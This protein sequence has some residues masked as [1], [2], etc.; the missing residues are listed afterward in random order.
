MKIDKTYLGIF[1]FIIA[2][3]GIRFYNND[4]KEDLLSLDQKYV[5]GNVTKKEYP[6][7]GGSSVTIRYSFA[8]KTYSKWSKIGKYQVKENDRFLISIPKGYEAE[9]I[10]LFDHPVPVGIEAP[11]NGWG[12]KPDF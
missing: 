1:I 6:P 3:I 9:G 4:K 5:I 2:L 8:G 11:L 10:I 7:K 12:E